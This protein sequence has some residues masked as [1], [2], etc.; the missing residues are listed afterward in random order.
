MKEMPAEMQPGMVTNLQEET[1]ETTGAP[2]VMTATAA[3]GMMTEAVGVR[4][5]LDV[6][7]TGTVGRT[8][9]GGRNAEVSVR[10]AKRSRAVARLR[11]S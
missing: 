7:P 4:D 2:G 3:E 10:L 9:P 8:G 1:M 11:R 6:T 5:L